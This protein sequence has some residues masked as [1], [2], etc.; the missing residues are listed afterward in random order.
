MHDSLLEGEIPCLAYVA[1]VTITVCHTESGV[2]GEREILEKRRLPSLRADDDAFALYACLMP[3][4][5]RWSRFLIGQNL[6]RNHPVVGFSKGRFAYDD[7]K[8]KTSSTVFS[9]CLNRNRKEV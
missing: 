2:S 1:P 8:V 3:R 4:L 6:G 9:S 7:E 5:I